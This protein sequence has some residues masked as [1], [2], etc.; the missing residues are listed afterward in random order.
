MKKLII[1]LSLMT[2][3]G[4]T[5]YKKLTGQGSDNGAKPNNGVPTITGCSSSQEFSV[6]ANGQLNIGPVASNA[7]LDIYSRTNRT[8]GNWIWHLG[9][10]PS[11]SNGNPAYTLNK[12]TGDLVVT[13]VTSQYTCTTN[14]VC[15]PG[16]DLFVCFR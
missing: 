12:T 7:T 9:D 4:C 2:L 3:A 8:G 1:A 14:A 6:P 11:A 13:N 5:Q 15:N 10:D 16:G